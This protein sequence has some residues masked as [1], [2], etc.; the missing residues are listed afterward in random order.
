MAGWSG[1]VA[2]HTRL[3]HVNRGRQI[4][5]LFVHEQSTKNRTNCANNC[6]NEYTGGGAHSVTEFGERRRDKK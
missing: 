4:C 1:S 5:E 6:K 2:R 3:I